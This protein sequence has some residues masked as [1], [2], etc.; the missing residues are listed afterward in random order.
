MVIFTDR[1]L[2]S[3]NKD[4]CLLISIIIYFSFFHKVII[5][6]DGKVRMTEYGNKKEHPYDYVFNPEILTV[7]WKNSLILD[8]HLNRG[9]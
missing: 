9:G 3:R 4:S 1:S 8:H 7:S 5:L 6:G 2:P